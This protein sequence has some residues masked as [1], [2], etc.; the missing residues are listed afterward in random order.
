MR[1][2]GCILYICIQYTTYD[3]K[4]TFCLIW[5][6]AL[7]KSLAS[8]FICVQYT[9]Y[10]GKLTFCL[11]WTQALQKSLAS[12]LICVQYTTYHGKLTFCLIWTQAL[13]KSLAST[14]WQSS[15]MWFFTMN[16]TTKTCCRTAPFNTSFCTVSLALIR[17]EWGSV[18]IK[19]ASI[20]LT[21]KLFLSL[22]QI[23]GFLLFFVS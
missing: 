15:H 20:S 6:Q 13:Q 12:T 9:T 10:H 19:P 23:F 3:G 22:L 17:W 1:W 4:L 18:Q 8:T 16:S 7:Q 21:W 14:L 11:I 2:K 5:T